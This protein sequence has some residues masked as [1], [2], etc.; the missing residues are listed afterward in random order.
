V[1][2]SLSNVDVRDDD[3]VGVKLLS[4]IQAVFG[5]KHI[6]KL[7]TAELLTVLNA[8]DESPWGDYKGRALTPR[9]LARLLKPYAIKPV[10]IRVGTETP[11]G[12]SEDAFEDAW[13]R[14][15]PSVPPATATS[16]TTATLA[17]DRMNLESDDVADVADVALP[18]E[19]ETPAARPQLV[20]PPGSRWNTVERLPPPQPDDDP[21]IWPE[22]PDD[23]S[24]EEE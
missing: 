2:I 4:D 11:R 8:I 17:A 5:D 12:Y 18:T 3:S 19:T 1:A 21:D 9:G 10:V 14:Y 6:D 24:E 15:L 23:F 22:P 16:A 7:P 20:L 13:K